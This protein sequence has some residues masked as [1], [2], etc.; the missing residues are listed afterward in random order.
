MDSAAVAPKKSRAKSC[1][2]CRQV[3]LRCDVREKYPGRCSRCLGRNLDC[4]MDPNFKRVSASLSHARSEPSTIFSASITPQSLNDDEFEPPRPSL[5]DRSGTLGAKAPDTATWFLRED[6]SNEQSLLSTYKL[7]DTVI[8]G[9][10]VVDLYQHFEELYH[11]HF[12]TLEPITS[13]ESLN[14]DSPALFW[15]IVISTCRFHPRYAYLHAQLLEPFEQVLARLLLAGLQNLKDLQALLMICQW[16]LELRNRADDPGWMYIGFIV[17]AALHMGLDKFQTEVLLNQHSEDGSSK[18]RRRTWLKVFQISSHLATWYGLRP[19]ISSPSDLHRLLEFY[20]SET[21]RGLVA[22]TEIQRQ[23]VRNISTLNDSGFRGPQAT[24]LQSMMLELDAIERRFAD[25]WSDSLS[26]NLQAV[27]LY[28][29]EHCL[30]L[31]SSH[32]NRAT[33]DTD[34]FVTTTLQTG[35]G[36]AISL[37]AIITHQCPP[38]QPDPPV[39]R[40]A[41]GGSPLLANPKQHSRAAFYA[42]I[43]LIHYLDHATAASTVDQDAARAAV[44]ALHRVFMQFPSRGLLTRAGRTIEVIARS[45]VPGQRRLEPIVKSRMGGSLVCNA[46]WL[47]SRLRGRGDPDDLSVALGQEVYGVGGRQDDGGGAAER[48]GLEAV[49]FGSQVEVFPWGVWDD[50]VYDELGMSWDGQVL[51]TSSGTMYPF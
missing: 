37:I 9:S 31:T 16:P 19:P 45:I 43:F 20:E 21:D 35:L 13:L 8:N 46:L 5:Q 7:G 34:H 44:V 6:H 2:A 39:T 42:C 1:T 28:T 41:A 26:I 14:K 25:I 32:P 29:L 11:V 33:P 40:L 15:A 4:R 23:M 38:T 47:A 49:G 24:M 10:I 48:E 50:G 51:Q 3:K 30:T 12:P 27:K 36:P 18:Y 17:N 22:A